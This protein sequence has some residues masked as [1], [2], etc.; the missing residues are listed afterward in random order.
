MA[1]TGEG[2]SER[3]VVTTYVPAYQKEQWQSHADELGMSQSE[4]VKTMV[5][6][7]RRGFG[8]DGTG[9]S[10]AP[11]SSPDPQGSRGEDG[12][13]DDRMRKSVLNALS[14]DSYSDFDEILDTVIEDIADE[15]EA[16]ILSLD[17]EGRI[18]HS[19]REGGYVLMED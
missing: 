8:G 19:P 15:V 3:S 12:V 10:A 5:Q 4:F 16:V 9:N 18:S 2:D 17:D 14:T 7:G 13:T 11:S 6:A 1:D